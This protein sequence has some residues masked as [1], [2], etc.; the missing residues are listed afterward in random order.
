MMTAEPKLR[1][2]SEDCLKH[3]YFA[4]IFNKEDLINAQ[5]ELANYDKDYLV[6]VQKKP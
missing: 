1:P 3:P 5:E 2:S 6:V 4:E